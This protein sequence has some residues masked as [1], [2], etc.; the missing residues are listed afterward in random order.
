[1]SWQDKYLP[2]IIEREKISIRKLKKILKDTLYLFW[3]AISFH[4]IPQD[5]PEELP[6]FK[7][8]DSDL[9]YTVSKEIYDDANNRIDKLEDKALK[10]LSYI[11]AIFAFISF[12]FINT[13]VTGSKIVLVI[14][15]LALILSILISFRC[16]SIK[17]RKTIYLPNI[18]D[19]S[20][21]PPV[22]NTN[23][24][25]IAES[26]LNSAIYN[27][28]IADNTADILRVSRSLVVLALIIS[29]L[30]FSVGYMGYI[31]DSDSSSSVKI[32]NQID[33]GNLELLVESGVDELKD[34]NARLTQ[35]NENKDLNNK[36]KNLEEEFEALR[37]ELDNFKSILDSYIE[38]TS[39]E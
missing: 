33:L 25:K 15:M 5:P 27:Q 26:Y 11:S 17:G 36:V 30:G 23:K 12:A 20:T 10:L 31:G 6:E 35:L 14:A 38:N 1:M 16:V 34:M 19:F 3:H 37:L 4:K 7:S 2:P 13:S 18:F 22:D 28:N 21:D 8:I 39:S 32:E 9:I 29:L 24:K